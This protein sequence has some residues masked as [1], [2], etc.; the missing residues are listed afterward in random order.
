MI[1]AVVIIVVAGVGLPFGA[2]RVARAAEKRRPPPVDG[3]G[4]PSDA[5]D[6]WLIEHYRLPALQ[7]WQVRNAVIAGLRMS[8]QSLR[9]AAH[10]LAGCALRGEL[11]LGRALR[12]AAIVMLAEG[13]VAVVLGGF[14]VLL[15]AS[16]SAAGIVP[17]ALGVWY[18]V[19]G[20]AILRKA[21]EGPK[22]AYELNA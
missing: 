16:Y 4:P 21:R 7:R 13:A 17:I 14:I 6:G 5:V 12:V 1:F 10:E 11:R 22:R 9:G 18:M 2:W 15:A 20:I 19:R 8:D 3:L